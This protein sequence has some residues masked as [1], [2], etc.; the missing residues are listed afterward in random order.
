MFATHTPWLTDLCRVSRLL[1]VVAAAQL[2]VIVAALAPAEGP[3]WGLGSFATISGLAQWIART[4]ALC[5][6]K[7]R[8]RLLTLPMWLGIPMAWAVP[9]L[10]A[11]ASLWLVAQVDLGAGSPLAAA[12]APVAIMS[13]NAAVITGLIAALVLRYFYLQDQ[14]Q[15]QVSAIAKSQFEA[16]QARIRPH[17]LFNSMNTIASLIRRDPDT[18]ERV[19][20]DLSDLFRAALGAGQ[21]DS[22]LGDEIDLARRYLAIEKLRLG[23]RLE[24]RFEVADDVP[25]T[26]PMPRLILQPLTENAI[27]HGVS[28]LDGGGSVVLRAWREAGTLWMQVSNPAPREAGPSSN[29]HAIGSVAQ[30]LIYHF[31]AAAQLHGYRDGEHYRC[32]LRVPLP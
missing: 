30:R 10:I 26:L 20:E 22:T 2:V 23:E 16:L 1:V 17:F 24:V 19:V 13:G 31:G 7:L 6:C 29:A 25:L 21:G 32:D 8:R 18:A 9:V 27:V 15:A 5:L 3:R 4:A 28:R 14:W 11:A 12:R